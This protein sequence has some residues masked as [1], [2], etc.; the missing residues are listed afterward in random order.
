MRSHQS[1]TESLKNIRIVFFG[2]PELSLP[3][4]ATLIEHYTVVGVVTQPDKPVGR[5]QVL[6]PPPVKL[7]AQQYGIPVFQ[8]TSLRQTKESGRIFFEAFKALDAEIAIVIA[9]GKIIPKEMLD[10][11]TYGFI[12]IHVSLLPLLRGA[13]P[14]QSAILQG[15]PTTGV[16][17]MRMDEGMDTGPVLSQREVTIDRQ[18][19]SVTLHDKL[20]TVGAKLLVETLAKYLTGELQPQQQDDAQAT[21]CKLIEKTD[22]EIDWATSAVDIDRKIRAFTPWPG[23]YTFCNTKRVKI[24]QAHLSETAPQ[25]LIIDQVQPE[26]KKPMSYADFLRGNH[27]CQFLP[28]G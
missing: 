18:E 1:T 16:T 24:L 12:N 25:T 17:I 22:G 20:K 8:P 15:L 27:D 14:I 2:T 5:K 7:L 4:L 21:Y 26:G 9:Y 6:T 13:S 10:L 11:P 28:R 23:A 19:T 3:T